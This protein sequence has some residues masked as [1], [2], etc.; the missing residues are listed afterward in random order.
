MYQFWWVFYLRTRYQLKG[1][2]PSTGTALQ[3]AD[4]DNV[5]LIWSTRAELQLSQTLR[6]EQID[7]YKPNILAEIRDPLRVAVVRSLDS[8]SLYAHV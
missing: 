6:P 8:T 5:E 2:F 4:G 1:V 7:S 3:M